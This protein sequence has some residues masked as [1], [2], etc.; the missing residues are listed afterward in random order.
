[1][2]LER[3][4]S[5]E[6]ACA[7]SQIALGGEVAHVALLPLDAHASTLRTTLSPRFVLVLRIALVPPIILALPIVHMPPIVY[8]PLI[9]ITPSIILMMPIFPAPCDHT[10]VLAPPP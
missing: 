8:S 10:R 5:S 7:R 1:M 9:G 4:K 2:I 3:I 6:A